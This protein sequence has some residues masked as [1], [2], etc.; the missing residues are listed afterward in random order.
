M[1]PPL[2][3]VRLTNC[4]ASQPELVSQSVHS[5]LTCSTASLIRLIPYN[6]YYVSHERNCHQNSPDSR[7][8]RIF[9]FTCQ[10]AKPQSLGLRGTPPLSPCVRAPQPN[11]CVVVDDVVVACVRKSNAGRLGGF[12][13]RVVRPR[14]SVHVSLA[15]K[16]HLLRHAIC[17]CLCAPHY[18]ACMTLSARTGRRKREVPSPACL[19]SAALGR[20]SPNYTSGICLDTYTPG[21]V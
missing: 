17:R 18:T 11:H 21:Y 5:S 20:F 6:L 16:K 9:P 8:N 4:P 10:L 1:E 2:I 13:G 14:N 19:P 15:I 3:I 12:R 7:H